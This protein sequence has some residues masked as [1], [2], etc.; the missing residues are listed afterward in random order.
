M[1][2]TCG[3]CLIRHFISF[4]DQVDTAPAHYDP[5]WTVNEK[6]RKLSLSIS[7]SLFFFS[8]SPC[9]CMCVRVERGRTEN[10]VRLWGLFTSRTD[11]EIKKKMKKKN[12][13]ADRNGLEY[14]NCILMQGAGGGR[15]EPPPLKKAVP[16]YDTKLHLVMSLQL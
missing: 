4:S 9:T 11:I 8:L 15:N 1:S 16:G 3:H 13:P 6:G 7:F 5:F 12:R 14:V 10:T 2:V